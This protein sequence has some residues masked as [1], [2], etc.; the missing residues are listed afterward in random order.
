MNLTRQS[1]LLLL[2]MAGIS[3]VLTMLLLFVRDQG[4]VSS[5]RELSKRLDRVDHDRVEIM[6]LNQCQDILR[7][8]AVQ[9]DATRAALVEEGE[10]LAKQSSLLASL[11]PNAAK[12]PKIDPRSSLKALLDPRKGL[13]SEALLTDKKGQ[14]LAAWP[15]GNLIKDL[16][17]DELFKEVANPNWPTGI[18]LSQFSKGERPAS[19]PMPN[20]RFTAHT[21]LAIGLENS[22]AVFNGL[23]LLKT[24]VGRLLGTDPSVVIKGFA[25]VAPTGS[26]L[27]LQGNGDELFHQRKGPYLERFDQIS[28]D[29]KTA[30][31]G[32]QATVEGKQWMANYDGKP[33]LLVWRRIG[34]AWNANQGPKALLTLVAFLPETDFRL[35]NASI[36]E[37]PLP[38][39]SDPWAW[40]LL[41]LLVIC[42]L[43]FGLFFIEK[44][45]IPWQRTVRG[46][47]SILSGG[48]PDLSSGDD[49]KDP[50]LRAVS[51]ALA[52]ASE[53]ALMAEG[54]VKELD[55]ALRRLEE[56]AG[57]DATAANRELS[58][59]REQLNIAESDRST[60]NN[61][62]ET[63][64]NARAEA[65]TQSSNM[66]T[67]LETASKNNDLKAQENKGLNSQVQDLLRAVEEQRKV[68]EKAS[69]GMVKKDGEVVRLSAINALNA[70]LKATLGVIRNY[71]STMLGS[72]GAISDAQ[73]EFLGVVINKSARL[74]RLINDLVELSEIGSG[75][76]P[77]RL[78]QESPGALVQE[79]LLNARPQAE[80][81]KISL[82]YV[83]NG[84]I[85][86]MN[87]DRDKFSN[88]V[89]TLLNQAIKVT[90]R[91]EKIGLLL[92]ER[93]GGLE[94]RL[95]DPGMSLPPDRAAKVFN[96][97]HGVDSQ[98]GPEFIGTG[99]RF[100][101]ARAVVEAHGGK[102]WIESQV[103][104]GKT[105]V[106]S[107]PKGGAKSVQGV[108]P[109]MIAGPLATPPTPILAPAPPT[110]VLL[111]PIIPPP[112]KI[113]DA[114]GF[115][116]VFGA[117]PKPTTA[118]PSAPATKSDP[119]I[120]KP[121]PLPEDMAAPWR[122][123]KELDAP[124]SLDDALGL[125][126][127]APKKTELASL[128][129][130]PPLPTVLPPM[131]TPGGQGPLA[132]NDKDNFD[133][134]FGALP[135]QAQAL[136]GGLP[137]VELKTNAQLSDTDTANF[138]ALFG[139][140]ATLAASPK[141]EAPSA[142]V[143][144][145]APAS[146]DPFAAF[147]VAFGGPPP[148][149]KGPP[150]P[151]GAVPAP[152]PPGFVV[153]APA[154]PS[155]PADMAQFDA[156]F[157]PPAS[158]PANKPSEPLAPPAAGS[159]NTLD[160]LNNMLQ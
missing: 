60:A 7:P 25:S 77:L 155:I 160:D 17:K 66:R 82:D 138:A 144:S 51:G 50:D 16:S 104:R 48:Q 64:L 59:L 99:L 55:Q 70:E 146:E 20:P 43:A 13:F 26:L 58:E 157:S 143:V 158:A 46:A 19:K 4:V 11:E 95:S 122:Q 27:L 109:A 127:L 115:S 71:I 130:L 41:L 24:D 89:Q 5:S 159:M 123:G 147:A 152:P 44:A 42:P 21:V 72:V 67:A 111:P 31:A 149:P 81:K 32:I 15:D 94:L 119:I 74:E 80:N 65:D 116:S 135:P 79:V 54:R 88:L 124:P 125:P 52:Q 73:Q 84:Q 103:G 40:A 53:R 121:A 10:A 150:P 91:S 136:Q 142:P 45:L 63:A 134:I 98:A 92:S 120:H 112:I 131:K 87:L 101:I 133:K 113:D 145:G 132:D 35:K 110:P 90:S 129:S 156:L 22:N 96:Q 106:L 49:A 141:P 61:K 14:V 9:I 128:S 30:L 23:L 18:A 34:N 97:F 56:Q 105:I 69:E 1:R 148:T 57:R 6:M 117:V 29:Y 107:L 85:D 68:A 78:L 118:M 39:Y 2:A 102:I 93:D 33:G 137:K 75:L 36:T 38:F 126:A 114:D 83:E 28:A 12:R 108:V 154:A 8:L 151:P 3:L 62:L 76:R 86:V 139:G 153:S 100:P 37:E 47:E 140:P